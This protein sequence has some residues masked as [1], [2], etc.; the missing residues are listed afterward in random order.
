MKQRLVF[1]LQ[2]RLT[3]SSKTN[4]NSLILFEILVV[5]F[6]NIPVLLIA[7]A[8]NTT[9]A[10]YLI[11]GYNT[12]SD[13]DRGKIDVKRLVSSTKTFLY[14]LATVPFLAFVVLITASR[15]EIAVGGY[16][17]VVIVLICWFFV[18]TKKAGLR[19]QQAFWAG[20]Y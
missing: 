7:K 15:L 20:N 13:L 6:A 5:G 1:G 19:Y 4:L 17:L 9:N 11:A 16:C 14:L 18:F 2:S 8:L 12:M 3:L 10:K